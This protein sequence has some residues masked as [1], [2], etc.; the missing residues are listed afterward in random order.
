M[1]HPIKSNEH[2]EAANVRDPGLRDPSKDHILAEESVVRYNLQDSAG[3][4]KALANGGEQFVFNT[5][6]LQSEGQAAPEYEALEAP[7]ATGNTEPLIRTH[8]TQ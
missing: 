5:N 1:Q 3:E 2:F 6:A 8:G 4:Y 7:M